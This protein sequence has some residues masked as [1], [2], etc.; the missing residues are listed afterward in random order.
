MSFHSSA[1]GN[2]WKDIQSHLL[3]PAL[4]II[5][6]GRAVIQSISELFQVIQSIELNYFTDVN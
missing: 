4:M 2:R 5:V 1:R 3:N 6:L